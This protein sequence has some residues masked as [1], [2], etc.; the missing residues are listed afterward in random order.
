M[1][2]TGFENAIMLSKPLP[3]G[4][5]PPEPPLPVDKESRQSNN[6]YIEQRFEAAMQRRR[7]FIDQFEK[8][9]GMELD[10]TRRDSVAE[11]Q[12]PASLAK[13]NHGA[14][15]LLL[16]AWYER[17]GIQ[18]AGW[19]RYN[20]KTTARACRT[21]RQILEKGDEELGIPIEALEDKQEWTTRLASLKWWFFSYSG[22]LDF[23]A[24][25]H[26]GQP[27]KIGSGMAR[28]DLLNH[29]FRGRCT[30]GYDHLLALQ[31]AREGDAK[32]FPNRWPPARPCG[33]YE[34]KLFIKRVGN[35][36]GLLV[37]GDERLQRVVSDKITNDWKEANKEAE[38]EVKGWPKSA[39]DQEPVRVMIGEEE[40][41][42]RFFE[43]GDED[44][45]VEVR[46][47]RIEGRFGELL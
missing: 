27:T 40:F 43:G 9:T 12:H 15:Q 41:E 17:I 29:S 30:S 18:N 7:D 35:S 14:I 8:D 46:V 31:A 24:A 5:S 38:I 28:I 37:V 32:M 3:I 34:Y 10:A 44:D 13:A 4:L 20:E 1:S 23:L 42:V 39:E 47:C 33:C 2:S 6:D 36:R 16:E 22:A 21:I 25:H 11:A 45:G 26:I 19:T